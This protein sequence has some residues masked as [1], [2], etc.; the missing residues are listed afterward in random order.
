[1][2]QRAVFAIPGLFIL[3]AGG[4]VMAGV[5]G[6]ILLAM[7]TSDLLQV[8]KEVVLGKKASDA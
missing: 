7:S 5:F 8:K 4:E 2:V 3:L 6:L 1:M